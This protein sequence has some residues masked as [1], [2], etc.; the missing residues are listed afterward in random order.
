MRSFRSRKLRT[1]L[2]PHSGE[3]EG[4]GFQLSV[5][6]GT[7]LPIAL[8]NWVPGEFSK[9]NCETI[10]HLGP[11]ER[12]ALLFVRAKWE[13]VMSVN[14]AFDFTPAPGTASFGNIRCVYL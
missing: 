6:I 4:T 5:V 9:G 12:A 13:S 11:P 3:A 7:V 1:T 2:V 8:I 10:Y 14:S